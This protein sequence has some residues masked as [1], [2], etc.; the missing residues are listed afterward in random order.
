[1]SPNDCEAPPLAILK[2]DTA[3]LLDPASASRIYNKGFFGTPLSGGGVEL[4]LIE[5]AL[6]LENSKI[7]VSKDK[8]LLDSQGLFSYCNP[9]VPGFETR[10]IV[11]RDL[12]ARGL[13]VKANH[14]TAFK[15][16][17]RGTVPGKVHSDTWVEAVSERDTFS[18]PDILALAKRLVELRKKFVLALVDE[19]GDLTYYLLAH[20]E[21][22][23]PSA[24]G[25]TAQKK[26]KG[27]LLG[28]KVFLWDRDFS[29]H[30]HSWEFYGKFLSEALGLSLFE[31]I[32]LKD[33]GI[34]DVLDP[35][36]GKGM[37]K[38]ALMEYASDL[39]PVF[40]TLSGVYCDLKSKGLIVK[41]GFKYGSHFRAYK[42]DP[43]TTHSQYLIWAA[44]SDYRTSWPE[45]SRAI[46]LAHTVNKEFLIGSR[47]GRT[48][49][50]LGIERM[51]P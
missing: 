41:T 19:E 40:E 51:R 45:I 35:R 4:D 2:D 32:Y 30:L 13:V 6:L 1:M 20:K 22:H 23:G 24:K 21:V 26:G 43:D 16:Y 14:P 25:D 42:G 9:R 37:S 5:T 29:K 3:K 46:R 47:K 33:L 31:A 10:Y 38:K 7:S 11:F 48:V 8:K 50:Y 49:E 28:D 27:L 15:V 17:P 18:L 12:R 44:Q 39:E 34:L 36:T